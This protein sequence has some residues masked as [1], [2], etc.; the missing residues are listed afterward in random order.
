MAYRTEQSDVKAVI[1][2]RPSVSM[3]PF[4]RAANSKINWLVLHCTGMSSLS[5]ADLAI[6]E[7][8]LAAHF[9][10]QY[11]PQYTSRSTGGA[12]GSFQGQ[13]GKHLEST[14]WGQQAILLDHSGCLQKLNDELQK[15]EK[16]V[17]SLTW[18]GKRTTERLDAF[19]RE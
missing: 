14:W 5:N 6:V 17:A 19:E 12:S 15:N 13:V 10:A 1:P 18:G 9:Y 4:I 11:D 3:E 8:W 16:K 2:T 7:T